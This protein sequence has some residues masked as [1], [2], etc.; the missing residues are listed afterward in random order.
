GKYLSGIAGIRAVLALLY[1]A[2]TLFAALALG[3]KGAQLAILG[4]LILNQVLVATI[5]Y[6]RSNIAGMQRFR[7]DSILSVLDRV[8]LIGIIGWLLWGRE[9]EFRIEW[10]VWA[11]TA[12]YSITCLFALF[13]V[14]RISGR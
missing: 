12:A 6:L 2:I 11:Q 1:T 9:G 14:L 8:L 13:L 5:L 4:W 3:Y 7:Q 10:F